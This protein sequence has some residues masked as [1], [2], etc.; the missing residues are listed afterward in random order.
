M[1]VIIINFTLNY[2]NNNAVTNNH[3]SFITTLSNTITG[4]CT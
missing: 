3:Y 1:V 2:R 4:I